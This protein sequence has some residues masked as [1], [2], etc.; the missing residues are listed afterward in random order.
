M[1]VLGV[2]L[3]LL[4]VFR[5]LGVL[6]L[7]AFSTC[8]VSGAWAL[9]AMF[10]ANVNAARKGIPLRGKLPPLCGLGGR[11]SFCSSG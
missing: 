5:G 2:L 3:A 1:V 11:C 9:V 10:L 6:G 7:D 4:L 8:Q